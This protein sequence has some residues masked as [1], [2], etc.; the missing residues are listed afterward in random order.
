MDVLILEIV[1][2]G[3]RFSGFLGKSTSVLETI[4]FPTFSGKGGRSDCLSSVRPFIG[5]EGS[6]GK[7]GRG[8]QGKGGKGPLA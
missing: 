3:R 4:G 1:A 7:G 8:G 5:S 2:L 6:D